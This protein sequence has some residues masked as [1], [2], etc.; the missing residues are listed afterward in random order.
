LVGAPIRVWWSARQNAERFDHNG[1]CALSGLGPDADTAA[2]PA[3][4]PCTHLFTDNE[5]AYLFAQDESFCCRSSTPEAVL[6]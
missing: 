5:D 4:G 2:A 3:D 1:E 6:G